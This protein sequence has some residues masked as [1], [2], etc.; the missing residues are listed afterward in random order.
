MT[1]NVSLHHLPPYF[2]STETFALF[3][4]HSNWPGNEAI[5]TSVK[6]PPYIRDEFL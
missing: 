3:P 1:K 2:E 4:G 5:Y 6:N